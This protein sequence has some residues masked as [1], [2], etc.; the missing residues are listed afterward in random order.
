MNYND[1]RMH[2]LELLQYIEKQNYLGYDPYDFYLSPVSKYL[3]KSILF[4]HLQKVSPINLRPILG[5]KKGMVTK[6]YAHLIDSYIN[7]YKLEKDKTYLYKAQITYKSMMDAAIVNT[8]TEI[9]W[10]RNYPFK[11]GGEIHDN[12][13]PLVY[14]NSRLGQSMINLYDITKDDSILSNIKKV[15]RNLLK[16]GRVLKRDGYTF[17]G[18]SP[19]KNTRL[20]FNVSMVA[21]ELMMKYLDRSNDWDCTINNYNIKN[22]CYDIIRTMIHY[23]ESDGAWTYGYSAKGQL[24]SQ[25]DFHQG[26]VADSLHNILDL[27]KDPKLKE[28]A[29]EAY[30][31]GYTY[32]KENQ[33]NDKGEFYWRFPKKFPLDIHNHAQGIISLSIN[34]KDTS[35]DRLE[36]LI[37]Q[38]FKS[39]WDNKKKRFYYQKWQC[40]TNKISYMRWCNSWMLFALTTYLT[41]QQ[42]KN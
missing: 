1:I 41:H 25:K 36:V 32:L 22:I 10:G 27:I 26:F 18:Y 35:N 24:F 40:F 13:K 8:E 14:L 5:I 38:V 11:T 19:D 3:P 16:T 9:G 29:T 2:S 23:Q 21:V 37:D 39:F 34:E 42:K 15:I 28:Q 12:K 30:N 7:L 6:V 17:I 33:I 31:K 20:T 4:L